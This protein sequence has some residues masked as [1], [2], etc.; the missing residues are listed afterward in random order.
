MRRILRPTEAPER[1]AEVAA[2][3]GWR[4]SGAAESPDR[5]HP[6]NHAFWSVGGAKSVELRLHRF[7]FWFIDLLEPGEALEA[8]VFD[9]FEVQEADGLVA[10]TTHPDSSVRADAVHQL[11][12]LAAVDPR[13][14]YVEA[15]RR[16]LDDD[17]LEVRTHALEAACVGARLT[18][19]RDAVERRV[20]VETDPDIKDYAAVLLETL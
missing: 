13:E 15:I 19:L 9:E 3:E 8:V 4:W 17:S 20:E 10:R 1:V 7:G 12:I 6:A 2:R 11:G 18:E 14:S 5:E 16:G